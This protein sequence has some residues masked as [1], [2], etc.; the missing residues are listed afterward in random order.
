[1]LTVSEGSSMVTMVEIMVVDM[2]VYCWSIYL[3]LTPYLL[4][5]GRPVCVSRSL[6]FKLPE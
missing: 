3:K 5:G 2:Q 1:M 4:D 6:S